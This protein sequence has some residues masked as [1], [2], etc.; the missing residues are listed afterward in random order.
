MK[1]S[2][3]KPGMMVELKKDRD[4]SWSEE[5]VIVD[6]AKPGFGWKD[7]A[8]RWARAPRF[9]KRKGLTGVAVATKDTFLFKSGDE[10]RWSPSVV[11]ASQLQPLGTT[12][13]VR[14]AQA[15]AREARDK[16]IREAQSTMDS[17]AERLAK[18]LEEFGVDTSW[19]I[20]ANAGQGSF[21]ITK[22]AMNA[23][24]EKLDA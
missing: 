15:K 8:G 14:E 22:N 24:L 11:Q 5:V 19:D 1:K 6:V 3:L 4:G 13:A 7:E 18:A 12:E 10:P 17:Q 23:L 9:M 21:T 20:R 16:R 2:E